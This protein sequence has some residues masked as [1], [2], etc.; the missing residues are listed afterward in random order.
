MQEIPLNELKPGKNNVRKVKPDSML[1]QQLSESIKSQGLLHNLVV[2]KNGVGYDVIDG[3]R[4][5]V[6]L[7][8]IHGK[9]SGQLINCIVL[10]EADVSVGLH[11]NMMREDMHPLDQC[12][13]IAKM[14]EDGEVDYDSVAIE[15][16]QTQKWVSQRI[17]LTELSKKA[18][19]QFRNCRFN[20]A[21]AQALTLG[22][23]KQQDDYLN[24]IS[25]NIK[26]HADSVKRAMTQ[27]KVP[28]E[29]ALFN[30][31]DEIRSGL[32]ISSDLFENEVYIN[33]VTLFEEL[34]LEY[35]NSVAEAH[36]KDGFKDVVVLVDEYV[37]TNRKYSKFEPVWGKD[38]NK[39]DCYMILT[40]STRD[41]T[42]KE[43]VYT[44][45]KDMSAKELDALESGEREVVLT[46]A[47]M[48]TPQLD[49]Y[50][51]MK[52]VQVRE[53]LLKD[54][55]ILLAMLVE[56]AYHFRDYTQEFH[57]IKS[58]EVQFNRKDEFAKDTEPD[59]YVPNTVYED[60]DKLREKV[61]DS[62]ASVDR[63]PLDFFIGND[64]NWLLD[65]L[66]PIIAQSIPQHVLNDKQIQES[67]GY[68]VPD[69]WF[70]P[71]EK[72]LRKYK[73]EQLYDI[74]VNQLGQTALKDDSK[75]AYVTA[76][77]K[78]IQVNPVFDP[79]AEALPEAAQ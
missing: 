76:I 29:T 73:V 37:F 78:H 48:S 40:Y 69:G 9:D 55:K 74:W 14:C 26:I 17:A 42:Y 35:V 56:T 25:E 30:I 6:A 70:K 31:S 24:D 72:W 46:P 57:T 77:Y 21:V 5:L 19:Q 38:Y 39:E 50:N 65:K 68:K 67:I 43:D 51:R 47:D 22:T 75:K 3:N 20:L 4:R 1:L 16:G 44:D 53:Y 8:K 49:L 7:K 13:V 66:A 15:F 33:N 11:A 58:T 60:A 27:N 10:S 2:Q 18:K 45:P 71:D 36:K 12:E 54:P 61:S 41:Y 59:N 32:D 62:Y 28:I 63:H 34:Q 79:F 64:T 23:H 52:A